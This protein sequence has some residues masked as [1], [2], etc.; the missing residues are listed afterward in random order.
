[1]VKIV[2]FIIRGKDEIPEKTSDDLSFKKLQMEGTEK[3]N[4]SVVQEV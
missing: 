4:G 2:T 1:M 3:M